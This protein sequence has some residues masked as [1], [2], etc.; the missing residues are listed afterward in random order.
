MVAFSKFARPTTG[1]LA[2][3]D[4]L[5]GTPD[6]QQYFTTGDDNRTGERGMMVDGQW[7]KS[8]LRQPRRC[9]EGALGPE[10]K[11]FNPIPRADILD[12]GDR[13]D[14]QLFI[15]EPLDLVFLTLTRRILDEPKKAQK[16]IFPGWRPQP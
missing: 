4:Q 10:R 12:G 15:L 1:I 6:G 8:C 11:C 14:T 3:I 5:A 16:L 13:C 2:T 9:P 7:L